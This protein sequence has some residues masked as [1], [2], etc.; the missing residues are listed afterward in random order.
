MPLSI[1]QLNPVTDIQSLNAKT[2]KED[3]VP[4]TTKSEQHTAL[5][6]IPTGLSLSPHQFQKILT[7]QHI[8]TMNNQEQNTQVNWK[9]S[10]NR[11]R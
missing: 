10:Q 1:I 5:P 6:R 3:T 9:T 2:V 11:G 4:D 8:M 7:T